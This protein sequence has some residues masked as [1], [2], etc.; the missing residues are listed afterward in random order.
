MT[1]S[2]VGWKNGSTKKLEKCA[3]YA[4]FRI[5]VIGWV[6]AVLATEAGM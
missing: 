5:S 4:G 6:P 1:F 2:A 3:F